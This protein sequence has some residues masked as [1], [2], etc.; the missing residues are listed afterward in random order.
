MSGVDGALSRLTAK[1]M[2]V[3]HDLGTYSLPSEPNGALGG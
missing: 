1:G 2:L 3:R